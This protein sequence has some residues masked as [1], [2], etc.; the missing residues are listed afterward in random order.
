M[1]KI[2]R[3]VAKSYFSG[4]TLKCYCVVFNPKPGNGVL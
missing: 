4:N 1:H 3:L 2:N